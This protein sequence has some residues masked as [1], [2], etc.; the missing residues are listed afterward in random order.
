MIRSIHCLLLALILTLVIMSSR[1]GST[2]ELPKKPTDPIEI[3]RR[4]LHKCVENQKEVDRRNDCGRRNVELQ[5]ALDAAT[6]RAQDAMAR[7]AQERERADRLAL[8]PTWGVVLL[9]V[10][11]GASTA[12]CVPAAQGDPD[13][14]VPCG[15]SVAATT[16]VGFVV[17]RW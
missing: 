15:V 3:T 16:A 1:S 2:Q 7:E 5:R 12:L 8:R 4:A 10:A 11:V 17:W 9:A 6:A 13:A 14:R